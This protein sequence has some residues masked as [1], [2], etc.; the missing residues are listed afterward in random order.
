MVHFRAKIASTAAEIRPCFK[1]LVRF[2]CQISVMS[3]RAIIARALRILRSVSVLCILGHSRLLEVLH[4]TEEVLHGLF[5][6]WR[7]FGLNIMF[8]ILF[9]I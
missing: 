4:F 7:P 5:R 8:Y 6:S 2:D 3:C 1:F 9:V